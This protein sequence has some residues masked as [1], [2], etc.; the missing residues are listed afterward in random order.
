ML[1]IK[2]ATEKRTLSQLQPYGRISNSYPDKEIE[3]DIS[4]KTNETTLF[5]IGY[6]PDSKTT[7]VIK[8]KG[9]LYDITRVDP[10]EGYKTDLTI[11]SKI[12]D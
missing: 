2:S 10:F 7:H 1:G 11:I 6:R 4:K 9:V 12:S 8:Y 5:Q 3:A